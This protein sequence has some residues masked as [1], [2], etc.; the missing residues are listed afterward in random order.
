MNHDYDIYRSL[1]ANLSDG[2]M[3][4]E[5]D[6]TVRI[7]NMALYQMFGLDPDAVVGHLF[8]ELFLEFEE[9][10][11]FTQIVL[12]TVAER[13]DSERAITRVR[14]G[15][16]VRSLCVTTSYLTDKQ[17]GREKPIALIVVVADVTEV[18][19]LRESELHMTEGIKQQLDELKNAYRDIEE[20]NDALS[21][22]MK[23]LQAARGL[24]VLIV[25]GIFLGVGT[26]YI[27]PL[28]IFSATASLEESLDV[29][30]DNTSDLITMVV[31]PSEFRSTIAL[32]GNIAPGRVERVVSPLDSH[33]RA[34]YAQPG[35]KVVQ[36]EPL[37]DLAIGQLSVDY[38][39]AQVEHIRAQSKLFEL[40]N[41]AN[42][43]EMAQAQRALRRARIE[44]D[45][46]QREIERT[47]FLLDEGIIAAAEHEEAQRQHENRKID[48][49]AAQR[50]LDSVAAKA[51]DEAIR[52]ARL[53]SDS[54]YDRLRA[55]QDKLDRTTVKAPINGTVLVAEGRTAKP[56]AAGRPVSQGELLASIAD[57]ENLSVV[58]TVNEI[59]VTKLALNQPALITGPGF[60][61]LRIEGA[62]SHISSRAKSGSQHRSAPKFEIVIALDKL[63]PTARNQLRVGMSAYVTVLVQYRPDALLVPLSAIAQR[64]G[65]SW[66]TIMSPDDAA[67]HQIN[68]EV[69][70]TTLDS[71]EVLSGISAGD[72]IVLP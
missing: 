67:K 11:E 27:K 48:F 47:A 2:V 26:W 24:A 23:R 58:L 61:G 28:D 16:E 43:E 55:Q 57:F 18:R 54:A 19:E 50:E 41:W 15:D 63:Q 22:T 35:R 46:A 34:I 17:D 4:I 12:D 53:E 69:G 70:L 14:I 21:V 33:I 66:I 1:L 39:A 10:E 13:R 45:S 68:V 31:E 44:L 40:E 71:V 59:D 65:K 30:T 20:Q 9:F 29:E 38:R 56:L 62:V 49:N 51:G 64:E 7:A 32:R 36:G 42:S 6:G 25:L 3:A 37:V 60:P 5:F 72:V 52:V 8:G